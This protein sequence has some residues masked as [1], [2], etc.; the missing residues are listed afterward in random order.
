ML[1]DGSEIFF[2]NLRASLS[3]ITKIGQ[4]QTHVAYDTQGFNTEWY[5]FKHLD[6][7]PRNVY[8]LTETIMINMNA[9]LKQA[10]LDREE[11]VDCMA[12]Q[13]LRAYQ[14]HQVS[15]T[16]ILPIRRDNIVLTKGLVVRSLQ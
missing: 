5:L 3:D 7:L 15:E 8:R 4:S 14:D 12:Y 11:L 16:F 13:A 9:I 6:S 2:K 10:C 1:P